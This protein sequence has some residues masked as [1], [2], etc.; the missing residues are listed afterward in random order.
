MSKRSIVH[1][2]LPTTDRAGSATFYAT[3]FGWTYEHLSHVAYTPFC[4]ANLTGGFHDLQAGFAPLNT[5]LTPGAVTVYIASEDID[6]DLAQI[7]ACGGSVRLPKTSIGEGIWLAVFVDPA[8]NQLALCTPPPS[9][10][11]AIG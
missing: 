8:G 10:A 6:A 2:D 1:V 5:V 3:V 7:E 11:V 9:P 4:A